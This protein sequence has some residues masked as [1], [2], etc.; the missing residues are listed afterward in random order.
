M[1]QTIKAS[2]RLRE[3][4]LNGELT[5]GERL[6]EVA[7]VEQLG[8]SR[9][10]IRSALISLAEEGL[11]EK[12][13]SVGYRVREFTDR[14]IRDAI[15]V[16]GTLEGMAARFATER[17]ADGAALKPLKACLVQLDE[18]LDTSSLTNDDIARYLDLNSQFH[19]LLIQL[20]DSFVVERALARIVTLPFASANAFVI[21]QSQIEQSWKI[22]MVA[23][24]Q[25]RG[26]VEA[27]ENGQGKRAEYLAQEH[28][29]LAFQTLQTVF[30]NR[31]V[32]DKVPGASLLAKSHQTSP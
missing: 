15:E 24:E 20:A 6:R 30:T 23:Q 28:A 1:S 3:L 31:S 9:T 26:I 10:P 32:L 19:E 16:R 14:D 17:G 18:V 2:V 29:L 7:L 22:F 13:S 8:M 4:I 5:P 12:V 25:H 11:L 21:A 27:I